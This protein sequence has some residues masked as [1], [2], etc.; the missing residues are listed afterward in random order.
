MICDAVESAKH[1]NNFGDLVS[2]IPNILVMSELEFFNRRSENIE[3]SA[4]ITNMNVSKK[5]GREKL[6]FST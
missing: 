6:E 2:I 1:H 4:V 5:G 3:L